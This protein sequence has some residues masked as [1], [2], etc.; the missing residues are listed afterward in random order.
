MTFLRSFKAFAL[1]EREI[2]ELWHELEGEQQK[3]EQGPEVEMLSRPERGDSVLKRSFAGEAGIERR[4]RILAAQEAVKTNTHEALEHLRLLVRFL[5][6]DFKPMF[7][8]RMRLKAKVN[9][10]IAFADLWHLYEHGQEVRAPNSNLQ[11]YKV[12][13]FTGGRD[14]LFHVKLKRIPASCYEREKSNVNSFIECFRYH[15]TTFMGLVTAWS[16]KPS[17]FAD[18]RV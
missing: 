6:N 8:M 11:V 18:T 17:R 10:P 13:K 1:Y 4:V 15:S 3:K 2:R 14:I 5:D 16:A 12:A 9:C 7:D